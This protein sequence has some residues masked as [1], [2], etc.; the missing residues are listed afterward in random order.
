M[1][2]QGSTNAWRS[3]L[4][5]PNVLLE[6]ASS[7]PPLASVLGNESPAWSLGESHDGAEDMGIIEVI[8]EV[9]A[10]EAATLEL[11]DAVRLEDGSSGRAPNPLGAGAG[12][13]GS[14][15]AGMC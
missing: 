6:S 9:E 8:G 7:V 10:T 3:L 11:K 5:A 4:K 1:R 14:G 13:G 15:G 2:A 12:A